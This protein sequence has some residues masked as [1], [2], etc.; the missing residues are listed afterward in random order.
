MNPFY[1]DL[2]L[3][4]GLMLLATFC[5]LAGY[6]LHEQPTYKVYNATITDE[7]LFDI[8]GQRFANNHNH[9]ETY[10]CVNYT[11]DYLFVMKSLGLDE[12]IDGVVGYNEIGPGHAWIQVTRNY[13]PQIAT[14]INYTNLYQKDRLSFSQWEEENDARN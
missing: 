12:N 1:E 13:E 14:Y 10:N 9:T 8:I 4:A 2:I 5:F 11:R 3:F 6:H 7:M